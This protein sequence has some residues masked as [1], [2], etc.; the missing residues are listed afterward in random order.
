MTELLKEEDGQGEE[1]GHHGRRKTVQDTIIV[2]VD[3]QLF[4]TFDNVDCSNI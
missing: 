3:R 2:E 1:Y 4:D